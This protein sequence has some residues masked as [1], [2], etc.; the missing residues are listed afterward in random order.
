MMMRRR[1][2]GDRGSER[3]GGVELVGDV[4]E[5][6]LL[7]ERVNLVGRQTVIVEKNLR[8]EGKEE[9]EV[10]KERRGEENEK[11]GEKKMKLSRTTKLTNTKQTNKQTK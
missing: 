4:L 3:G 9:E 2:G 1:R 10:G 6:P 8:E 5:G 11:S 7:E